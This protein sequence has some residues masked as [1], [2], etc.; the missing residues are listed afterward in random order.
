MW[1]Q[2]SRSLPPTNPAPD[3]SPT[4]GRTRLHGTALPT[5]SNPQLP[6]PGCCYLI[7]SKLKQGKH[8]DLVSTI[9]LWQGQLSSA[10]HGE[11]G[12]QAKRNW[13]KEPLDF[14]A[15]AVLFFLNLFTVVG[16]DE[17]KYMP[18][19][20]L[21]WKPMKWRIKSRCPAASPGSRDV[22]I[23][24]SCTPY[25]SLWRR[26]K[27]LV[28]LVS[29]LNIFS[30]CWFA[31]TLKSLQHFDSLSRPAKGRGLSAL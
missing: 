10:N 17:K 24:Q 7:C 4:D 20:F 28:P 29:L 12:Y 15:L 5:G 11:L 21:F 23:T 26:N 3:R 8:S 22:Q 31:T 1:K 30:R 18:W 2:V 19:F 25:S 27:H 9:E 13:E 16:E 6:S 14:I